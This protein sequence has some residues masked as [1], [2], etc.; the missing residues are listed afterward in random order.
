MAKLE[1]NIKLIRESIPRNFKYISVVKADAYG[2]GIIKVCNALIDEGCRYFYVANLE[3]A[4]KIRKKFQF[5]QVGG[6]KT[7]ML[8]SKSKIQI[9]R[10]IGLRVEKMTIW[11]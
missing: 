5:L 11:R 6:V 7:I 3:E 8:V 4:K 9:L 10:I 1:R 2:L